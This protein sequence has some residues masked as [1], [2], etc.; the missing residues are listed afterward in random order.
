MSEFD[1]NRVPWEE[2]IIGKLE[3]HWRRFPVRGLYPRGMATAF[4]SLGLRKLRIVDELGDVHAN[5]FLLPISDVGSYKTPPLKAF[6]RL[7][8]KLN[9]K[10]LA[11]AKFTPVGFTELCTGRKGQKDKEDVDP[12][13]MGIIIRDEI[14]KL[15]AEKGQSAF[16]AILAFL[17]ELWDGWIEGYR[18]RTYGYEGGIQVYYS[19]VGT[20]NFHFLGTLD[21]DFWIIG[22][23][24]RCLLVDKLKN[25]KGKWN[26][27]FFF[28]S[29]SEEEERVYNE[30]I[31]ML[32][33]LR[34]QSLKFVLLTPAANSA[35]RE[36]EYKCEQSLKKE[37]DDIIKTLITKKAQNVLRLV[38][39]YAASVMS[40]DKHRNLVIFPKDMKRAIDDV[41]EY[42][43]CAKEL[44][45][46]WK[47][48]QKKPEEHRAKRSKYDLIEFVTL[49][50]NYGNGYGSPTEIV[51]LT[52]V[53]NA[54]HVKNTLLI[55]ANKNPPWLEVVVPELMLT[56]RY[57]NGEVSKEL[58][59][60]FKPKSGPDP[61]IFKVTPEGRKAVGL[62]EQSV[63]NS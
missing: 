3:E 60:R 39:P 48:R 18:T 32:C 23:G 12:Q 49:M 30:V 24:A 36:Y 19:M 27:D 53:S 56:V 9:R 54:T 58:Y 29:W 35:W 26:E 40:F 8:V 5:I 45:D 43:E 17:C 31:D 7:V 16:G 28:P 46:E 33:N 55:G 42:F 11:P 44:V 47:R 61:I 57:K 51:G 10:L 63:A 52:D 2:G 25:R 22:L 41:E 62:E 13:T 37:K 15:N 6:R 59:K 1:V 14:S 50:I 21:E 4:T 20:S 38:M 34:D